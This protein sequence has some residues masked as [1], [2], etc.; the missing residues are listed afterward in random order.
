VLFTLDDTPTAVPLV[1]GV[2]SSAPLT[3]ADY[4]SL[5]ATATP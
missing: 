2:L 3:F 4:A 5:L 1:S